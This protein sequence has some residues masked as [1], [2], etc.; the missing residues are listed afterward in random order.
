MTTT[1]FAAFARKPGACGWQFLTGR[2]AFFIVPVRSLRTIRPVDVAVHFAIRIGTTATLLLLAARRFFANAI[3]CA[4]FAGFV[5]ITAAPRCTRTFL[6]TVFGDI[7]RCAALM[8]YRAQSQH[9]LRC[10]EAGDLAQI[11]DGLF[12]E[13]FAIAAT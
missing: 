9:R 3:E 11:L 10:A 4:Q 6:R 8:Q 13:R 7:A 1:A 5:L 2:N 12:V